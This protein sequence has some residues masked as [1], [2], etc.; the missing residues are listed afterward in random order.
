MGADGGEAAVEGGGGKA[1]GPTRM[2]AMEAS[3]TLAESTPAKGK[4]GGEAG[5]AGEPPSRNL[6]TLN[7]EPHTTAPQPTNLK[8]HSSNRM[9][10]PKTP[11][12]TPQTPLP[13]PQTPNPKPKT[14][15]PKI[16]NPKPKTPRLNSV[17]GA[18]GR[19]ERRAAL[20]A[21]E[22]Q[23]ASIDALDSPDATTEI[24]AST[25]G[26]PQESATD[27]PQDF[28]TG[29]PQENATDPPQDVVDAGGGRKTP[30]SPSL[31][32]SLPPD[33]GSDSPGSDF[34]E[35]VLAT[36]RSPVSNASPVSN[37]VSNA[38][39]GSPLPPVRRRGYVVALPPK[40]A[41]RGGGGE[42]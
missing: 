10:A 27:P 37:Y 1:F 16:S 26:P 15:N 23:E 31:R 30:P 21:K 38:S 28:R 8:H 41:A 14:Q 5:T 33:S 22:A 11:H 29:P 3:D 12:P 40:G 19:R 6:R 34:L 35:G 7:P 39:E 17:G 2:A 25:L 20:Q 4:R 9:T 42:A 36:P 32:P 18:G 13:K 24:G